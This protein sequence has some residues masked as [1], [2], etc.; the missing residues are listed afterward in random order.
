MEMDISYHT[1]FESVDWLYEMDMA[2]WNELKLD[3]SQSHFSIGVSAYN[4]T[5]ITLIWHISNEFGAV[6]ITRL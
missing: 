1:D 6:H 4:K 2:Q 5:N 3:M